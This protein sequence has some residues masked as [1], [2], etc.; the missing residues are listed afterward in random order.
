MWPGE[1]HGILKSPSI[2][3]LEIS[4]NIKILKS[5]DS[6]RSISICITLFF[7]YGD[8]YIKVNEW[9]TVSPWNDF[10]DCSYLL[11]IWIWFMTA[12]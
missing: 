1:F 9:I 6:Y 5:E 10:W 12:H 11:N 2:I 4:F 7:E 8:L 3:G